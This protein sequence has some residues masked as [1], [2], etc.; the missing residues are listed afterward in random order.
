MTVISFEIA[1]FLFS[2]ISNVACY[3]IFFFDN[4]VITYQTF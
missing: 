1:V 4:N 2:H 3:K